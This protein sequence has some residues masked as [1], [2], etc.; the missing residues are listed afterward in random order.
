MRKMLITT[1]DMLRA[2]E[3]GQ[4]TAA[5]LSCWNARQRLMSQDDDGK[6]LEALTKMAKILDKG[7]R[8]C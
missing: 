5:Q 8:K 1:Q 6:L 4:A 3:T 7:R 2:V